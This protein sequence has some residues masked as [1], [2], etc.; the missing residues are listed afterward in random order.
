MIPKPIR[1][2]ARL[3]DGSA[4][5]VRFRSGVIEIEPAPTP[6]RLVR[7]GSLT[8][9]EPAGT[10]LPVLGADLVERTREAVASEREPSADL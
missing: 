9:A 4:V 7:R 10:S 1:E 8:V 5:L 6:V 3:Q 2:A